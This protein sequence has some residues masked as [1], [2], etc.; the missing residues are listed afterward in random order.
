MAS[1]YCN[2]FPP[3]EFSIIVGRCLA[4]AT[5]PFR[6]LYTSL[7]PG[8]SVFVGA[9]LIV[10][11]SLPPPLLLSGEHADGNGR[12]SAKGI[13]LKMTPAPELV[14]PLAGL[15]Q[16]PLEHPCFRLLLQ[17]STGVSQP[18]QSLSDL[19]PTLDYRGLYHTAFTCGSSIAALICGRC[20][21][22]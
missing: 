5:I 10:Y 17:A 2:V 22:S 11:F 3:T 14:F 7:W 9:V 1:A 20:C 12:H 18:L 15:L 16:R 21:C 13:D 6:E 8:G 4:S 19:R